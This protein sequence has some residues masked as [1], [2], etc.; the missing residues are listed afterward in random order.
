M[1]RSTIAFLLSFLIPGAG[2]WY[3]HKPMWGAANLFLVLAVGIVLA[4]ILPNQIIDEKFH[5]FLLACA[6]A[7]GGF[8]H[9]T[10]TRLNRRTSS[11]GSDADRQSAT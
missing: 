6:A 5:Y 2:L 3:L 8:A 7:S 10:A 11:V 9:A 4:F 1:K